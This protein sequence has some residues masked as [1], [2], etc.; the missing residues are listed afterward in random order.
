M[1][2]TYSFRNSNKLIFFSDV[3]NWPS[4]SPNY[5]IS[6]EFQWK[7]IDQIIL[8]H[9]MSWEKKNDLKY[10]H[11]HLLSISQKL[12]H[13]QSFNSFIDKTQSWYYWISN[14]INLV[15]L[16]FYMI[17]NKNMLWPGM[18]CS[19]FSAKFTPKKPV[20]PFSF[21]LSSSFSPVLCNPVFYFCWSPRRYQS[22]K[23]F[24]HIS[25]NI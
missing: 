2:Y 9:K 16:D 13:Q 15:L 11:I 24:F 19:F 6:L 7:I 21:F 23:L 8:S 4:R 5:R 1:I 3:V 12:V 22:L 14:C 17:K 20:I 25:E 18:T 10:W